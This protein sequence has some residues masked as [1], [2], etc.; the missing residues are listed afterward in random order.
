MGNVATRYI[1][2]PMLHESLH[3]STSHAHLCFK[4]MIM[5]PN[6]SLCIIFNPHQ[7]LNLMVGIHIRVYLDNLEIWE[8]RSDTW[9]I[10]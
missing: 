6:Y 7:H 8:M 3:N 4:N 9:P 5:S 1:C 10:A 2:R